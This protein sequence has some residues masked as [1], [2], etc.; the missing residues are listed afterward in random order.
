MGP[1]LSASSYLGSQGRGWS[2]IVEILVNLFERLRFLVPEFIERFF[3]AL[4]KILCGRSR[5]RYWFVSAG[6]AAD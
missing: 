4:D 2:Q 3:H 1:A 5:F 6:T